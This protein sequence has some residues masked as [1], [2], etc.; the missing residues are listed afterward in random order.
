M[1]RH[2]LVLLLILL[3]GAA[4]RLI[5]LNNLSPPGIT[6]DEVAHWLIN[7]DI[8]AGQHA[9]YFTEA[10][11]HEAGYHYLQTGF[12]LLLGDN[13]LALRLPSAFL[14]LLL[15]AIAYALVRHLF[16][17]EAALLAAGVTAVLLWPVFFSRLALRAISLP[18]L[19]GLS[20]ILWW[21][22][23]DSG[24]LWSQGARE[25]RP[26]VS[27]SKG[28]FSPLHPCTPAPLLFM[29]S[30]LL[31]G[32]S[33][34]TYMAA[35]A[36]PIFYGAWLVYLALFQRQA[37][38]ARWRGVVLF[39]LAYALVAAP[40][41][42]YLLA[43]PGAEYR[44][45]EVDAPLRA[46][47]AGDARPLLANG[48]AILRGLIVQ[49]DPL[50]RQNVAGRPV[51]D[52]LLALLFY[53]GLAVMVWRWRTPKYGFVLL[54]LGTSTIPSLVTIDAPSSIRL[55]NALPLLT[56]PLSVPI[57]HFMHRLA[58]FSP[59]NRQ[60]STAMLYLWLAMWGGGYIWGT[61]VAIFRTWPNNPEVQ[62]V[63]QA[64]F[65]DMG[66]YLDAATDINQAAMAGWS[67]DT[68]DVP[69]MELL[70]ERADLR[71]SHFSP[72]DGTLI[73]PGA[74]G[75][76]LRPAILELDAYWETQLL[77]WGAEVTD[78]GRFV[79]Y[80]LPQSLAVTPEVAQSATFG[81]E[82]R[83]LGFDW[84]PDGLVSYWQVVA[85]PGNGRRLFLH[86]LDDDGN[87]LAEDYH[88]DTADPQNLWRP[89]WQ[90]GDLILQRHY[91]DDLASAARLRLGIYDPYTCDP[92]PC[93][94][95]STE[96]GAAFIL[97]PVRP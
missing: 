4:L 72:L 45:G 48:W 62:F 42:W 13:V 74:G 5:G 20:A 7:R 82:L 22:A 30:G 21:R 83:L 33:L 53:A 49:G 64:A 46:L 2:R 73:L 29:A 78:Y 38:R 66:V 35:R 68:M 9:V 3:V 11:G 88:W 95:I 75:P 97:F 70:L 34:H 94:N 56:V 63:W 26:S 36:V 55:I 50:W 86:L 59:K 47:L 40:L 67:P 58:A 37:L 19:S 71:L 32:L 43:N 54:W 96:T 24:D 14:G 18:V 81:G 17:R 61:A 31:A 41:V 77:A 90:P 51:F 93:Q 1:T 28:A 85:V 44:I 80:T 16:G 84:Q 15:V 87:M 60:L 39:W 57:V 8:L 12:M 92:G 69:T 52:P 6:H 27:G 89:H 25:R 79:Q 65:T 91:L 76:I 10:Y 23:W